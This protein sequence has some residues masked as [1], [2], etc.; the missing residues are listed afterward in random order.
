M[1][2]GVGYCCCFSLHETEKPEL[3]ITLWGNPVFYIGGERMEL[4]N[5]AGDPK[6]P[7]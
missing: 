4:W 2:I 7:R 1:F 5:G 3:R 6:E